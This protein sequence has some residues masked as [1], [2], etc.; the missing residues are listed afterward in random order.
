L[1]V[2][3][4]AY[5]EASHLARSADQCLQYLD[6]FAGDGELIIVDDGS[7]DD[8][9]RIAAGLAQRHEAVRMMRHPHN[10]GMGAGMKTGIREARLDY[11]V[12]LPADGQIAPSEIDKLWR[13]MDRHDFVTSIYRSRRDG[14]SRKVLS[15][16]LRLLLRVGLGVRVPLEGL[17][18]FPTA[19]AQRWLAQGA[20]YSDTFL[21][22][23][24]LLQRAVAAGLSYGVATIDCRPRAGGRSKVA[25]A[26]KIVRILQ[27]MAKVRAGRVARAARAAGCGDAGCG[28]AGCGDAGC[29]DAGCGDAGCGDAGCGDAGRGDAGCGDTGRGDAGCGD[30]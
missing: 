22:S 6:T 3:L 8:S 19:P 17:Y 13:A 23:F 2:V 26:A 28:D 16:G 21:F 7:T 20:F 25:N 10:R 4:L 24:E 18:L 1:S 11:F 9:G 30:A 12:S 5:N 15:G 14:V 27:E 29:G